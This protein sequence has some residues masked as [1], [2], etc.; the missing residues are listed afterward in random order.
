MTLP[1]PVLAPDGLHARLDAPLHIA[2]LV[3]TAVLWAAVT[4]LMLHAAQAGPRAL[5]PRW[6]LLGGGLL[7]PLA[8]LTPLAVA[9]LQHLEQS[10]E[11]SPWAEVAAVQG[12]PWWWQV[13]LSDAQGRDLQSANELVLPVGRPVRLALSADSL[14]H[15]LWVP[16]L[17]GKVDLVPGRVQHLVLQADRAGSWRAPCAEFCGQ[18]HSRMVLHVVALAAA[19]YE[20]WLQ[21]QA[22]PA[23]PPVT[24]LQQQGQSLFVGLR[25][26]ACH[27]VRGLAVQAL[28]DQ[29]GH[30]GGGPD[31]THLASRR[32]LGAGTLANDEAGLR[33]W[34]TGVQRLKPGARMPDYA[35]LDDA[36]LDALV[37]YL[38]SLR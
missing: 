34:I 18:G 3:G 35:H 24:P 10:L 15:S 29:A 36:T 4:A 31:L 28:A 30:D 7:L 6:W 38:G 21:G 1:G 23:A 9:N 22:R 5:R 33:A 20:A 27:T 32:Y 12:R 11:A 26:T 8:V 17:A 37:A 13:R 14:I 2:L 19:D 25:C 16:A